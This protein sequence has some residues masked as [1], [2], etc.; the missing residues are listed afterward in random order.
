MNDVWNI[1]INLEFFVDCI[2]FE[3]DIVAWATTLR[4]LK[5]SFLPLSVPIVSMC[6]SNIY[7]LNKMNYCRWNVVWFVWN[8]LMKTECWWK[9]FIWKKEKGEES[10]KKIRFLFLSFF[11]RG[12][13]QGGCP[14]YLDNISAHLLIEINYTSEL[15]IPI[16]TSW[17]D[18]KALLWISFKF[19]TNS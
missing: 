17:I 9:Y 7:L 6:R 13:S 3:N 19:Q 10:F 2:I 14:P 8:R 12:S 1:I 4:I 15:N 5:I 16:L 18:Q 11:L